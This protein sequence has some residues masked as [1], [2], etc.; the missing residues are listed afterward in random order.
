MLSGFV[1]WGT[2][3]HLGVYGARVRRH[4]E[5]KAEEATEP[6]VTKFIQGVPVFNADMAYGGKFG[7]MSADELEAEEEDWMLLV[8]PHTSD[9]EIE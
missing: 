6:E 4:A 8:E 2:L 1:F 9:A 5:D 7:I 3:S